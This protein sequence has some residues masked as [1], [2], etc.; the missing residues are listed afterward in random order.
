MTQNLRTQIGIGCMLLHSGYG[1]LV[2]YVFNHCCFNTLRH[3][4]L[5]QFSN[6][7]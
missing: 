5:F 2:I 3:S 7:S 1:R 4:I 6:A